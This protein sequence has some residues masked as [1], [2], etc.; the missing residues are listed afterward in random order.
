MSTVRATATAAPAPRSRARAALRGAIAAWRGLTP[1]RW[2]G[3]T[4]VA[5]VFAF[6]YSA[7]RQDSQLID[8]AS[9][10]WSVSLLATAWITLLGMAVAERNDHGTTMQPG[11]YLPLGIAASVIGPVLTAILFHG[12]SWLVAPTLDLP[13]PTLLGRFRFAA[14]IFEN[15]VLVNGTL[16]IYVYLRNASRMARMAASAEL[17]S[18]E[19]RGR[20][21]AHELAT[22]QALV[23]PG[24]LLS[25][26]GRIEQLYEGR[27]AAGDRLMDALIG[28]LRAALPQLDDERSSVGDQLELAR[29]YLQIEQTRLDG[30][31]T[32]D[33][34]ASPE[35]LPTRLPPLL[36]PLV[37]WIVRRRIEPSP[38][39]GR[40]TISARAADRRVTI[41]LEDDVAYGAGSTPAEDEIDN[42]RTQLARMYGD[43]A[44]VTLTGD[45]S[46]GIAVRLEV[47]H[48]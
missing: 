34:D 29:A 40:V 17:R 33:I 28:Y 5:L 10:R 2:L 47:P 14:A 43:R 35:I 36:M 21:V 13:S 24:F 32:F 44:R 12:A 15:L 8:D 19:I 9:L 3:A 25:T 27:A 45:A 7:S 38:G 4:A 26:L 41:E 18:V 42:L 23:D 6:L 11:R 37:A 31:L 22:A 39:G 48:G 16:F 1:K 20:I 30:R 46:R